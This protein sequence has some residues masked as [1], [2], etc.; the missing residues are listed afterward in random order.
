MYGD[1]ELLDE[2]Y[3]KLF[4]NADLARLLGDP[5][6]SVERNEK[7]RREITPVKFATVDKLNFI[8]MYFSSA[9]ETDNIYVVRGF[10][11][12]DYFT[13]SREDFKNIQ[14]VTKQIFEDNY[15]LRTSF[16]NEDSFAKGVFWYT[17]RYRPLIYA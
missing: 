4:A 10:L 11:C 14:A 5:Q 15:L 13:R 6:S 3:Y 9:T 1:S 12:V 17:E 16:R 7:I 2:L 8:A